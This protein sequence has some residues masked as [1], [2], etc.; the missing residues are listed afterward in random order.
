M[1]EPWGNHSLARISAGRVT[2]E[3]KVNSDD[4]TSPNGRSTHHREFCQ[5][6]LDK[7]FKLFNCV[8]QGKVSHRYFQT[9]DYEE[10]YGSSTWKCF[11]FVQLRVIQW[12]SW[13]C[14]LP[15]WEFVEIIRTLQ[16]WMGFNRCSEI[17]SQEVQGTRMKQRLFFDS[18]NILKLLQK[19]RHGL[20]KV[21]ET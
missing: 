11:L 19:K 14:I 8:L 3:A 9:L 10:W 12:D 13:E 6:P 16:I 15:H 1:S 20:L 2:W 7:L 18:V 4:R 5:G 17:Y 21:T